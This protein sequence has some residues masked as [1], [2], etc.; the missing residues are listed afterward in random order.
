MSTLAAKLNEILG[1][2]WACVRALRR[3]QDRC[4][5]PGRREVIRRV[6]KDGSVGCATLAG[7][8]R[9]CGARPTDV[10]SPR[11]SLQLRD[12][13]LADILDLAQSAQTHLIAELTA[14]LDEPDLK[15]AR[16]RIIS[17]RQLH[18]DNLRWLT[19]ARADQY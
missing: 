4:D 19:V 16:T 6:R 12:E 1:V 8:I 18:R 7:V 9:Q 15:D 2:E 10:P 5:D 3:A 11:F 17:L 14:L 13:T